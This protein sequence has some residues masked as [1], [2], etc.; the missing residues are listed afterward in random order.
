MILP[1]I[2]IGIC[3]VG[4]SIIIYF[5]YHQIQIFK[6]TN[7]QINHLRQQVNDYDT[8]IQQQKSELQ[9]LNNN[10]I[11]ARE[12]IKYS[13]SRKQ[14]LVQDIADNMR[15]VE[16]L[17]QQ[18]ET[19]EE[20]FRRNY[21]N[22]RKEW[23]EARQNEYLLMQEDFVTQF[24]EENSKKLA[25]A[26]EL[27]IKLD[28]LRSAADA[29]IEVAKRHAEEENFVA[30]HSLQ[31]EDSALADIKK[32]ENIV[33][34]ISAEAGEAVAKIIWK[35]YYEKPYGDMVGRVLGN[36]HPTGI[37]RITNTRNSKCYIGQAV[38]IG[39]RWRQHIRRAL[40]AEPRTQ[41]KLYPAMYK[42]GI[43]NFTF[44]VIEE[45]SREKLNEREDYWQDFYHAKEYGYSI[46]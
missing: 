10:L 21:M 46:K 45:C 1:I 28:E 19:T 11:T 38:D 18:F 9:T 5:T 16:S 36:S 12:E 15:Q 27:S 34:S 37:Y 7:E 44:E 32:L 17:K 25:A 29:A 23:V 35:V 3:L 26:K 41:N 24:R 31:L 20:S 6:N 42:E 43:E 30:Y 13:E 8:E 4:L 40:N 2:I 39:D 22:E 33:P 14:E